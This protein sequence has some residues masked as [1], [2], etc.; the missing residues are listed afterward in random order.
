V[1]AFKYKQGRNTMA[2]KTAEQILKEK[3]EKFDA[4]VKAFEEEKTQ[5]TADK[6]K[7]DA[8]VKA[9]EEEKTQFTA[10]KEKFDADVKAFEGSKKDAEPAEAPVDTG[11]YQKDG[12]LILDP[13]RYDGNTIMPGKRNKL[14][15]LEKKGIERLLNEKVISK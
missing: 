9:F 8:D 15:K 14:S 4:D 3:Q 2:E 7:F 5:F 6:E 12:Y 11:S 10:D 1:G 13:I